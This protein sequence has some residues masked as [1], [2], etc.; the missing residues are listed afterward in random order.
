MKTLDQKYQSK[1]LKPKQKLDGISA[2]TLSI[3]HDE[4][5]EGYVKKA[6]EIHERLETLHR[7]VIEGSVSGNAT[8]SELRA[9]KQAE[10]YAV[11]GIYLHEWYFESLRGTH[12]DSGVT[13]SSAPALLAAL[14]E[15]FTSIDEFIK[16]FS[17]CA[18]CARG[19]TIL[20][21]DTKA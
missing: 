13:R 21:W 15:E 2:R 10:T 18:K 20:A 4:L 7:Q 19:W 16:V 12:G 14:E 5:Y 9:L 8:S 1:P 17:E 11:N 3:H 6:N